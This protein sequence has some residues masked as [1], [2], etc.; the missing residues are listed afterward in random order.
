MTTQ[1]DVPPPSLSGKSATQTKQ[2]TRTRSGSLLKVEQVGEGSAEQDLDQNLYVNINA[3]WVNMKGA[4]LVHPMLVF[5]GKIVI[6]TVPG[7]NQ[8]ISWTLTNLLYLLFSYFVFH[9]A[10]GIPFQSDLHG[11]AYDELTLWEQID[12]GAQYTP[13]KKWL[14]TFPIILF[15]LS[16]HYT[17]YDPW[18]F[19]MNLIALVALLIPRLPQLHRQRVRFLAEEQYHSGMSTPVDAGFTASGSTTPVNGGTAPIVL[20]DS[21][22]H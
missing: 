11:G 15:L 21:H 8:E 22:F 2:R 3:D 19:T 10:T 1:M 20:K 9:W 12:G 7:M 5:C 16:T 13:T 14:I 17:H 18:L 6:D 4:W